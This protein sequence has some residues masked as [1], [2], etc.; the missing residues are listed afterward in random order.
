MR[1]M[2]QTLAG[3]AL[4]LTAVAAVAGDPV[5]FGLGANID[6]KYVT[7]GRD[8]TNDPVLQYQGKVSVKVGDGELSLGAWA[9]S[10][11]TNINRDMYETNEVHAVV[12]YSYQLDF[13]KFSV[14]TV[15]YMFPGGDGA[16]DFNTNELYAGVE[17]NR[18]PLD[19]LPGKL[20]PSFTVYQDVTETEG[21]YANFG[22]GWLCPL[23]NSSLALETK[24]SVGWGSTWNNRFYY[25]DNDK[26]F[27]DFQ[28][29]IGLPWSVND[30]FRIVPAVKY[31]S[32]MDGDV[33]AG[34]STMYP[35]LDSLWY[36]LTVE[37]QF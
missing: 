1:S 20:V 35:R 16:S 10:N 17:L 27:A 33:R 13:A 21:T 15:S 3:A 36:S 14:G 12:D 32:L 30:N 37:Y 23:P 7:R 22:L 11:L 4:L 9:N 31:S 5:S 24:A 19:F 25:N 34:A 6:G 29:S 28:A 8:L 18:L 26:G 2:F